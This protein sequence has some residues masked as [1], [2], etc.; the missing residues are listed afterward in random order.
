[1]SMAYPWFRLY[2]E[3]LRDPKIARL[4]PTERWVW[5]GLLCMASDAADRG[6]LRLAEGV[7]YETADLSK[8]LDAPEEDVETMLEKGRALGMLTIDDDGTIIISKFTARQYNK[9]SDQPE[10]TR[11]RK[12]KQRDGEQE[13]SEEAECH[14][15]DDDT[16]HAD[17]TPSSRAVTT[18]NRYRTDTDSDQIQN[19]TE[20]EQTR[21]PAVVVGD[22]DKKAEIMRFIQQWWGF[23]PQG[24]TYDMNI[25]DALER[26][27]QYGID[28]VLYAFRESHKHHKTSYAYIDAIIKNATNGKEKPDRK[29]PAPAIQRWG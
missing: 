7:P 18:Q 5:I 25:S 23:H 19:R 13:D 3:I 4:T 14:A 22:V 6:V 10:A 16:G 28:M 21:A 9:P 11:E 2:S 15:E 17:V 20:T 1:M 27:E 8:S 26:I 12:R 29:Q 24:V